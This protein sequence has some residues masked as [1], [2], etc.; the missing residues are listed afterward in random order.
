MGQW[1]GE[2]GQRAQVGPAHSVHDLPPLMLQCPHLSV[3][4]AAHE[5]L[6]Q[7]CCAL[8]KACQSYPIILQ[9]LWGQ[10][11]GFPSPPPPLASPIPTHTG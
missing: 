6:G 8:H 1:A 2:Q 7:L 3:R 5:A 10:R 4:K 11:V 9:G